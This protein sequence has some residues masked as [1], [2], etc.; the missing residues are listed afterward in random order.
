MVKRHVR[1][2]PAEHRGEV[3]RVPIHAALLSTK[4]VYTLCGF[5]TKRLDVLFIMTLSH[6]PNYPPPNPNTPTTP[7]PT[8]TPLRVN[9]SSREAH[10]AALRTSEHLT[11][12][13]SSSFAWS[14]YCTKNSEGQA[15]PTVSAGFVPAYVFT[16]EA[17]NHINM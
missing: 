3:T 14:Y 16:S 15:R 1:L 6:S 11:E 17:V 4:D 2:D 13:K 5:R 10:F 8:P 9:L 7:I 12:T